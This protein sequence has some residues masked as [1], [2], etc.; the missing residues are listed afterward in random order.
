MKSV[1]HNPAADNSGFQMEGLRADRKYVSRPRQIRM[2]SD[3]D[4]PGFSPV[5][6]QLP[7]FPD[8]VAILEQPAGEAVA[9]HA[10]TGR[11][12]DAG[13]APRLVSHSSSSMQTQRA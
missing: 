13:F 6:K 9:K 1:C 2:F 4:L 11:L 5:P 3:L 10:A 8:A 7:D 12:A